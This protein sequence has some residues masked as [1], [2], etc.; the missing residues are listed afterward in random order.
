[1]KADN[2]I[3]SEGNLDPKFTKF[4]DSP[5]STDNSVDLP[6]AKFLSSAGIKRKHSDIDFT[7]SPPQSI[8]FEDLIKDL[9]ADH[10]EVISSKVLETALPLTDP[11]TDSDADSVAEPEKRIVYVSPV[12]IKR[13]NVTLNDIEEY[14]ETNIYELLNQP[15]SEKLLMSS[16]DASDYLEVYCREAERIQLVLKK[17]MNHL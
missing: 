3:S 15:F 8:K 2:V 11:L 17:N 14:A 4:V 10:S 12:R 6:A 9:S 13:Q 7:M 5:L 1:M 16:K